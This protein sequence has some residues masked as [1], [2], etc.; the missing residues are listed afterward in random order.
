MLRLLFVII[1]SLLLFVSCGR[2]APSEKENTLPADSVIPEKKMT[3]L[4]VDVHLLEGGLMIRRNRG[5]QDKAWTQ[6]AYRKLFLRYNVSR[7]QFMANLEYYQRDPK[8]FTRMYDTVLVRLDKLRK[9]VK[10]TD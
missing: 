7:T 10:K 9:P 6:E 4:L 1:A 3:S 2:P 5:D 8:N